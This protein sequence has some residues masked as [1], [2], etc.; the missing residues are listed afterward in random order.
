MVPLQNIQ[1]FLEQIFWTEIL[2]FL[3]IQKCPDRAIYECFEI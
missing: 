2:S 1:I 3:D